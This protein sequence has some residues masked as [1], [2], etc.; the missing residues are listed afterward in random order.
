[1]KR[2][3][4]EANEMKAFTIEQVN[5]SLP[6][7]VKSQQVPTVIITKVIFPFIYFLKSIIRLLLNKNQF[8]KFKKLSNNQNKQMIWGRVT[9]SQIEIVESSPFVSSCQKNFLFYFISCFVF[10]FCKNMS[11]FCSHVMSN[12]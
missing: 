10:F 11:Y 6:V 8:K 3:N 2:P 5:Q 12:K 9:A 1:M 7:P 4:R